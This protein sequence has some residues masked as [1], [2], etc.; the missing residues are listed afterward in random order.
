M[1][2]RRALPALSLCADQSA[3]TAIANDFGYER[4][5]P[6][7]LRPSPRR[8]TWPLRSR[9]AGA[10]RMCWPGHGRASLGHDHRAHRRRRRR[11]AAPRRRLLARAVARPTARIQESH[12]LIAHVLC[13]LVERQNSPE[14]CLPRPRRR[15]QPQTARGRAMSPRWQEFGLLPDAMDD[16]VLLATAGVPTIVV[17]SNQRGIAPRP[18]DKR[19]PSTRSTTGCALPW[20]RPAGVSMRDLSLP[21]RG[22]LPLSQ[23]GARHVRGRR[24][25]LRAPA[26]PDRGDRRPAHRYGSRASYRCP[27]CTRGAGHR[28]WC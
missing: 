11:L 26:G 5:S 12:I 2:D 28:A 21:A 27:A 22:R 20:P 3:L 23:A 10:R 7:S 6:A 24:S 17:V 25:R 15:D 4:S 16:L 14:R 1:R 8:G 19:R 13:E 9:P 18:D